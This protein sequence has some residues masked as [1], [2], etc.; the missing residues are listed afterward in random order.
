AGGVRCD[1]A[2]INPGAV[3]VVTVQVQATA[4]VVV[5]N[6]VQGTGSRIDLVS[7]NNAAEITKKVLPVNNLVL[8]M[9]ASTN[10]VVLGLPLTYF[11]TVTN[12]GPVAA[13]RVMLTNTYPS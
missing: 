4:T 8:S 2:N 7:A 11:L 13:T 12:Q 9:T 10:Q 5:A 1:V 3:A 6:R